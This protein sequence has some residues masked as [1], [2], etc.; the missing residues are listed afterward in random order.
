M[1]RVGFLYEQICE[2]DNIKLAHYNASKGKSHYRDVIKIERDPNKYLLKVH[3]SL[4]NQEFETS[5]Y[6]ERVIHD[7]NK[8]RIIH[9]LPYYPDRIVHHAMMQILYPILT[10]CL[11]R[12]TFQS[13]QNRGVQ[14]CR[15]RIRSYMKQNEPTHFIKIDI[16]KFFPSVDKEILKSKLKTKIKCNK[17]LQLLDNL[18][19]S[20]PTGLPIGN[21]T[22]QI[23]G[24]F[25]LSKLDWS[26][27]QTFNVGYFRYCDDIL[28][29][30]KNISDTDEIIVCVR[31][32]LRNLRLKPKYIKTGSLKDGILFA[33][34]RHTTHMCRLSK[35]IVERINT[36]LITSQSAS[37][38]SYKGIVL[39]INNHS[40]LST[41][42]ESI[43]RTTR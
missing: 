23:L 31:Q 1:K 3:D 15:D 37:L 13:I 38:Q 6:T 36:Q 20:G 28:I 42:K 11:I 5:K 2:L 12:D 8:E 34:Y 17:T 7:G 21:Y 40:L 22:S 16:R 9:K 18:I 25:Y 26:L 29:L 27:V 41:I 19:D 32:Q 35:K 14:D 39:N 24:N 33:G 43:G 4:C 10:N 30:T